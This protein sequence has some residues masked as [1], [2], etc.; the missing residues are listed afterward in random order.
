MTE[1]EG[2]SLRCHDCDLWQEYIDGTNQE[3]GD[4]RTQPTKSATDRQRITELEQ[5][6]REI[7]LAQMHHQRE[8]HSNA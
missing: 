7:V 6:L 1:Y 4:L 3:L 5:R 8:A 2:D